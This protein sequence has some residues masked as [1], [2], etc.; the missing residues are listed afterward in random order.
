M[1]KPI[2]RVLAQRN[3]GDQMVAVVRNAAACQLRRKE[4]QPTA[5]EEQPRAPAA[6]V[7]SRARLSRGRDA[8]LRT[9][10]LARRDVCRRR[11][12]YTFRSLRG[13]GILYSSSLALRVWRDIFSSAAA[14]D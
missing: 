7:F 14:R 13:R 6:D 11:D 9:E 5:D 1:K 12:G 2:A 10:C 4:E 8:S 3:I